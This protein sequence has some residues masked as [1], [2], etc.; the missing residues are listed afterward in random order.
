MLFLIATGLIGVALFADGI[1]LD[2]LFPGNYVVHD[3]DDNPF[4]AG[5]ASDGILPAVSGVQHQA[6]GQHHG[7]SQKQDSRSSKIPLQIV[8]DQD[9]PSLASDPLAMQVKAPMFLSDA[10]QI[11]VH[12][13]SSGEPL[14][15]LLRVLL[16]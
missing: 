11:E 10:H 8:F 13:F 2:D 5:I 6:H 9:S 1:N 3:D 15:L 4:G 14:H 12:Q 7:T 16:I